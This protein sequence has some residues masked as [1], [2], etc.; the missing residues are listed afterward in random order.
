MYNINAYINAYKRNNAIINY[1]YMKFELT[2]SWKLEVFAL[3]K[4]VN[5]SRSVAVYKSQHDCKQESFMKTYY[6]VI[7]NIK[8]LAS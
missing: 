2:F 8:I 3:L 4:W 6:I 5:P 1:L 7:R